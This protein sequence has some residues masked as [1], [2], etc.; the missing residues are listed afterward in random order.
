VD[1][2]TGGG[3]AQRNSIA[4][5]LMQQPQQ[6]SSGGQVQYS[7]PGPASVPAGYTPP[8]DNSDIPAALLG[9]MSPTDIALFRRAQQGQAI[10]TGVA[11]PYGGGA[12]GQPQ[13]PSEYNAFSGAGLPPANIG[14]GLTGPGGG[15]DFFGGGSGGGGG[16]AAPTR[17]KVGQTSP[18]AFDVYGPNQGVYND[19]TG[20]SFGDMTRYLPT[21]PQSDANPWGV[22]GYPGYGTDG[23][24]SFGRGATGF[25][26]YYGGG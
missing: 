8:G 26:D 5:T 24:N 22:I 12:M 1:Q 7:A 21:L 6:A 10:P 14:G 23:G 19:P 2:Q 9:R 15:S 13:I 16:G 25:N 4:Q 11:G 20:Q 18:N 3:D 17:V